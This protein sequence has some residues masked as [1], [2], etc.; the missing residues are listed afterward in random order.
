MSIDWKTFGMD[1]AVDWRVIETEFPYA[2]DMAACVQDKIYHAEGDVLT[3]TR[4]VMDSLFADPEFQALPPDRRNV[5]ALAVLWHD[6]SKPETR[7]SLRRGTRAPAGV[8]SASR[9]QGRLPR[10]A[11]PLARGRPGSCPV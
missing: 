3:H 6:V 8:A 1:G 5:M 11:R 2:S 9:F 4:L 10:L 7:G